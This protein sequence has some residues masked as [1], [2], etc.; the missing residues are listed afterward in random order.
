[1]RL[2]T[3]VTA[4]KN[5]KEGKVAVK[6][7]IIDD[8]RTFTGIQNTA[9]AVM[10]TKQA[11]ISAGKSLVMKKWLEKYPT[12]TGVNVTS[13]KKGAKVEEISADMWPTAREVLEEARKKAVKKK[14]SKMA[15]SPEEI[16]RQSAALLGIPLEALLS[17]AAQKVATEEEEEE[18]EEEEEEEEEEE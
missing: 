17:Q 7:Y 3:E 13:W 18:I 16:L 1:M 6:N 5:K 11:F 15:M 2:E 14:K 8:V 12:P 10:V 9:D 4:I